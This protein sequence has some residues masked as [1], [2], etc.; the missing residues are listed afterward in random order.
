MAT[1]NY[2]PPTTQAEVFSEQRGGCQHS[3]RGGWHLNRKQQYFTFNSCRRCSAVSGCFHSFA[4]VNN[5]VLEV[6]TILQT[7]RFWNLF[8]EVWKAMWNKNADS[9]NN[10]FNKLLHLW[11]TNWCI[12]SFRKLKGGQFN[13]TQMLSG[14]LTWPFILKKT[15][16]IEGYKCQQLGFNSAFLWS[17]LLNAALLTS[18]LH[19]LACLSLNPNN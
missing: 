8:I 15:L 6:C 10:N 4:L 19:K 5:D 13:V 12:S 18:A 9:N 3:P 16:V 1:L 11:K 7:Q 2:R 17:T 14:G